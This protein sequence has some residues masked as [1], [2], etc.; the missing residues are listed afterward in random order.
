[1]KQNRIP[2]DCNCLAAVCNGLDCIGEMRCSDFEPSGGSS[3]RGDSSG[4][5]SRE[6]RPAPRKAKGDQHGAEADLAGLANG[7]GGFI[8]STWIYLWQRCL[9]GRPSEFTCTASCRSSSRVESTFASVR[10]IFRA[11]PLAGNGFTISSSGETICPTAKLKIAC[12]P[13]SGQPQDLTPRPDCYPI[14][15]RL[16]PRRAN[17][18]GF[19]PLV[20]TVRSCH[21][22]PNV[23]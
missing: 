7:S 15:P 9:F 19:W 4:P 22:S 3:S 18:V 20:A 2:F 1:V 10:P 5:V 17:G 16:L 14:A 8:A 13:A 6:L 12:R 11:V 21:A 23:S